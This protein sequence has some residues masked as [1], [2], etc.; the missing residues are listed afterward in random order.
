MDATDLAFAG[1]GRQAQLVRDGDVSPRELVELYLAR[2]ERIDPQ[3][4]AIRVTFAE[5]AL[6]EADQAAARRRAGAGAEDRPLLGV[7]ILIKDD[8]DVAGELTPYGTAATDGRPATTD[9]EVVRR[10]RAAGAIVIGKTNVPE[11]TQWPFTETITYGITRNPWDLDRTPG[12]SSGGSGAAVAAG[13]AAA[14]LATDGAGSIRI[15]ASC[16]ALFGLKPQRGRVPEAPKVEPWQDLTVTGALTRSVADTAL[17]LDATADRDAGTPPYAQAAATPPKGPLRIAYTTRN[18]LLAP[19]RREQREALDAT[20]A[21]LRELGH[22]V[23]RVDPPLDPVLPQVIARYLRGI[24]DDAGRLAHPERLEPRTQ[25]MVR[26]GRLLPDGF[27]RWARNEEGAT[28]VRLNRVLVDHD[29]L[30]TPGLADLP[31]PVGRYDG[32]GALWTFNGVARFTPFTPAWNVTG[33]PA[34]AVPAGFTPGGV[35]LSV[36]LVGRPRDEATLLSL[37]AQMETARPWS[38]RRPTLAE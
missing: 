17:W 25:G 10:L 30:L 2:I 4:N 7:P 33:Q 6:I 18:P 35:P 8:V 22:T 20:I 14:A 23:E 38:A 5:R 34:A 28:T 26:M 21:L 24:A 29:V 11:L 1:L 13:L 19:V 3:L 12:G 31:M 15:P 36:Q 16:C 27:V 32:R 9:A 37:A